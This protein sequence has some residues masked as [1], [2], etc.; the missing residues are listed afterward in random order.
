MNYPHRIRLRGPWECQPLTGAENFAPCKI[1]LPC[2]LEETNLGD[3]AGP[4]RFVRKFGYPGNIDA[5]ERIWLTFAGLAGPST[6]ILNGQT[7]GAAVPGDVE[8]DVTSHLGRR[9]QLE[10]LMA[11]V[12]RQGHLWAEVAMEIRCSA[13]LKD[14]QARWQGEH[15]YLTGKVAGVAEGPLELYVLVDGRHA[16]YDKVAAGASFTLA[17]PGTPPAQKVRVEL[18]SVSTIWYSWEES[19]PGLS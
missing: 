2:R 9:N 13:Y 5:D 3:F 15:L 17:V 10:I 4:A 19:L 16:A 6:I 7:L 14:M 11:V 1:H 8:F 12:P 18:V